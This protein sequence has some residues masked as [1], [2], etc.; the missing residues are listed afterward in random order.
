MELIMYI[1]IPAMF[2]AGVG[3]TE[4]VDART[5]LWFVGYAS[6]AVA[7]ALFFAQVILCNI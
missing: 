7:L 1:V 5:P 4:T 3:L 2:F 6:V